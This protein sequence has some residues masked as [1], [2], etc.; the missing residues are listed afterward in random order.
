MIW[1]FVVLVAGF[2]VV[3]WSAYQRETTALAQNPP[4]G[5]I[6]EV[7][8]VAVHVEVIGSGPDLVLIHGA[9]GNLRDF[10]FDLAGRLSE[11]YRVIMFDRPGL[12]WTRRL[13]GVGGVWSIEAET[14]QAQ[15]AL[16]QKAAD[17]IGVENPIVLGHSYGGAVALAWGL[18]RPEETAALVLLAGVSKPWPGGLG[19]LY[20]VTGSTLGSA[21][22]IPIITA[23]APQS[24]VDASITAI[25]APQPVPDGYADHISP[26]MTL[27]RNSTRANTQQV[28]SLRPQIVEMEREYNRLKMPVELVHGTEDTIVPLEIHSE[29]LVEDLPQ[30]HLTRLPG[31]GHMPHHAAPDDVIAAIDRAATNAGLR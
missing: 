4:S 28:N 19:W 31:I 13:P 22:V 21:L 27:R 9:S 17:Q 2:G 24:A 16:L 23:F 29:R 12:G 5:D 30:A 10:S 15:A 3:Q 20:N 26:A 25:F 8:G 7:D 11:R 18:S 6:L 14:P 1:L